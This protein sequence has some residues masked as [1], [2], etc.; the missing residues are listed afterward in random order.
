MNENTPSRVAR[1]L[2]SNQNHTKKLANDITSA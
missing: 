2:R 1:Y